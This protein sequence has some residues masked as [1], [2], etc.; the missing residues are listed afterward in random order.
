MDLL[1]DNKTITFENL[2]DKYKIIYSIKPYTY[3]TKRNVIQI[4]QRTI[5]SN[6][7]ISVGNCLMTEQYL[8]KPLS[9]EMINYLTTFS[10][11]NINANN[12]IEKVYNYINEFLP[13]TYLIV[14]VAHYQIYFELIDELSDKYVLSHNKAYITSM[15]FCFDY[16]KLN[17]DKLMFNYDCKKYEFNN[18]NLFKIIKLYK[19]KYTINQQI[20]NMYY[21]SH[22][23]ERYYIKSLS[24]GEII[25]AFEI[26]TD[27]LEDVYI[28]FNN[29][30]VNIDELDWI[31][32]IFNS[33]KRKK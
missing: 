26:K 32:Q 13:D 20:Q 29:E 2:C 23:N 30:K 4:P 28:E 25:Y 22:E 21:S 19:K 6:C 9:D 12:L 1:H 24:F 7:F 11:H 27:N 14:F 15:L 10:G 3:D 18:E 16:D 5:H 31:I 17:N 33:C 8:N